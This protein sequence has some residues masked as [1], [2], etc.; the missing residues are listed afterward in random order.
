MVNYLEFLTISNNIPF[1]IY[2]FSFAILNPTLPIFVMTEV[3][4]DSEITSC[5]RP[6]VKLTSLF[7]LHEI[8]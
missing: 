8:V 7:E 2:I 6:L 4:L 3:E 5:W 1:D